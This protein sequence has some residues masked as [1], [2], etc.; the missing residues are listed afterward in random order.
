MN[1][2]VYLKL[3]LITSPKNIYSAE[4]R[5]QNGVDL[6]LSQRFVRNSLAL[7]NLG[8]VSGCC[9]WIWGGRQRFKV[10]SVVLIGLISLVSP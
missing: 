10:S 7:G 8:W 3:S 1:S 6:S 4:F 5:C 9:Q 2:V